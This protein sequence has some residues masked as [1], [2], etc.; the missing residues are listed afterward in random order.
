MTV[1]NEGDRVNYHGLG[2]WQEDPEG[3]MGAIM[4]AI[5]A[6]VLGEKIVRSHFID[7]DLIREIACRAST[8]LEVVSNILNG[9]RS[10]EED[11]CLRVERIADEVCRE[12]AAPL[13]IDHAFRPSSTLDSCDHPGDFPDE[14]GN[15]S[16][17]C[18]APVGG[19]LHCGAPLG[20]CEH[21]SEIC[22]RSRSKHAR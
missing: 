15:D 20:E 9:D 11:L 5:K 8:I 22:A 14:D 17:T 1:F 16:D 21:T 18:Y 3:V 19:G 6:V 13:V 4:G 12:T 2:K 10:Y 7:A